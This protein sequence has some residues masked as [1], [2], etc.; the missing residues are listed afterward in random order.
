MLFDIQVHTPRVDKSAMYAAS[1]AA[2]RSACLSRQVG[3]AI[4]SKSGEL[5]GV[6]WNDVPAFGGGLYRDTEKPNADHRCF[7]WGAAICH[8]DDRKHKLYDKIIGLLVTEEC[9]AV[10]V[11]T[12]QVKELLETTDIRN[13]IEYS[14]AV[15]AEMEAILS[16]ARTQKAGLHRC[17]NV[18]HHLPLPQLRPAHRGSRHRE[19]GFHR[20]I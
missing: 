2:S 17:D 15:H 11:S 7:R 1:S 5:I 12:D 19:R 16:V 8:N 10:G 18:C 14:R 3:A 20:T 4:V 9:L 6:G 13:L